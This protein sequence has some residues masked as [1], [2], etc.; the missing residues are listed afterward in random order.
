MDKNKVLDIHKAIQN[1][2]K[3]GLSNSS[4][5]E[6]EAYE[7][8]D[9]LI[10]N[11]GIDDFNLYLYSYLKSFSDI[12]NSEYHKKELLKEIISN[13]YDEEHYIS[14]CLKDEASDIYDRI[15]YEW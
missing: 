14:D 4:I 5:T 6:V 13:G 7:Y 8:I 12:E 2:L 9:Y 3:T 15:G 1:Q 11:L 10:G